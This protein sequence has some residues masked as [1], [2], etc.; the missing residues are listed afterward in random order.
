MNTNWHFIRCTLTCFGQIWPYSEAV[1]QTCAATLVFIYHKGLKKNCKYDCSYQF[2]NVSVKVVF[3]FP[4]VHIQV[5]FVWFPL[6][7]PPPPSTVLTGQAPCTGKCRLSSFRCTAS[8]SVI[9]ILNR[10][11]Y[12]CIMDYLVFKG[13]EISLLS[14]SNLCGSH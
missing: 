10:G 13:K 8:C 11:N 6:Y 14:L 9:R 2:Q 5:F 12:I 1:L 4:G 3:G 7:I